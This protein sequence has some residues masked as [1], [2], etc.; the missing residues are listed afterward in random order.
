VLAPAPFAATVR[1]TLTGEIVIAAEGVT[2]SV[3]GT[4]NGPPIPDGLMTMFAVYVPAA[5]VE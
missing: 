4:S 3:T 2:V 1:F 5:R